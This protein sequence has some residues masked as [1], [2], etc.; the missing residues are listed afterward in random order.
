[1]GFGEGIGLIAE[2]RREERAVLDLKMGFPA[3]FRLLSTVTEE[4]D[5]LRRNELMAFAIG[6]SC[7]M[8]S[9]LRA[10]T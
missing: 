8:P 5:E 4:T 1:M 7:E 10:F 2:E 6:V 3:E 9:T